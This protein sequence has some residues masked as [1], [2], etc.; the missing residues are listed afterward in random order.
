M[1]TKYNDAFWGVCFL[2]N[3]LENL[4]LNV[5]LESKALE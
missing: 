1:V 3:G 4:T 5:V 2:E